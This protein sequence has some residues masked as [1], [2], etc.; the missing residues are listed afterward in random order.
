MS[1]KLSAALA[2]V[3]TLPAGLGWA[4]PRARTPQP[5][6]ANARAKS[7]A[8]TAKVTPSKLAR[9]ATEKAPSKPAARSPTP[10]PRRPRENPY[11]EV[12]DRA[13]AES[14]LAYRYANLSDEDAL[15][16]LRRRS[17]AWLDATPPMPGVRTPVRLTGPLHGVTIRSSLSPEARV[18]SVF[19]ILDARLA[20]ALDDFTA[21]LA[22]HDIV[23]AVHFTIY[24]P[25]VAL[26]SDPARQF[27]HPGGLAIDVGALRKRDGRWLSVGRHWPS[28]I[29][30]KTCGQGAREHRTREARELTGIVCE[31]MD[32]RIFHYV[33]TPNFDAAHADHVHLEIKPG[34]RSF[35]VN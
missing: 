2:L 33:L 23:E 28:G 20:L 16:E 6:K 7:G 24:R 35:I 10:A 19:E 29:G 3:L 31:A 27:R 22:K 32:Q 34:A 4:A 9:A 5:A 1:A 21:L 18:T 8:K 17:I 15:A 26:S 13:F 30:Q 25:P 11:L 12:P 14:T